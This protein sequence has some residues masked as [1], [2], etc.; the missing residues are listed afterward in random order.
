MRLITRLVS[1]AAAAALIAVLAL[2]AAAETLTVPQ[3]F[4]TIQAAIDA[5]E[6]GDVIEIRKGKYAE[7]PAIDGKGDLTFRAVGK[8]TLDLGDAPLGS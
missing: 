6:D 3:Q 4:E 7:V 8:V 2:P 1:H 5:A